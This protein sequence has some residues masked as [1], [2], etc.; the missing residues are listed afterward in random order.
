M[1]ALSCI[2]LFL[3]YTYIFNLKDKSTW[4]KVLRRK[5]EPT[6][7]TWS[8]GRRKETIPGSELRNLVTKVPFSDNTEKR[9]TKSL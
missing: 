6:I 5:N 9:A 3:L 8:C 7:E 1:S 2:A 4:G